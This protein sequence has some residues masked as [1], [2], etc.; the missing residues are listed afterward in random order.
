MHQLCR[1]REIPSSSWPTGSLSRVCVSLACV[2]SAI[3]ESTVTYINRVDFGDVTQTCAGLLNSI[4]SK[5]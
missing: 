4:D 5:V 2:S 3:R 1:E